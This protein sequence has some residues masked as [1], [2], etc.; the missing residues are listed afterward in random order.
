MCLARI[1]RKARYDGMVTHAIV[2]L[3]DG[4]DGHAIVPY[5]ANSVNKSHYAQ[6]A[7]E[8]I[9]VNTYVHDKDWG[10]ASQKNR[11][12]PSVW[13]GNYVL[14][15]LPRCGLGSNDGQKR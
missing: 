3:Y 10:D 12:S 7:K 9:V 8:H 14:D 11:T 6:N 2:P 13:V 4:M 5:L 15:A 1:S